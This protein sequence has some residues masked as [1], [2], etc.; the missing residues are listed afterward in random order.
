[1]TAYHLRAVLMTPATKCDDITTLKRILLKGWQVK[2]SVVQIG[3][4]QT[5][6][7][8]ELR[9]SFCREYFVW[10]VAALGVKCIIL[11]HAP[12]VEISTIPES[13]KNNKWE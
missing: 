1:M 9:E 6:N 7:D 12:E 13:Y 11:K 3:H 10:V 4:G 5:E 2:H 8:K